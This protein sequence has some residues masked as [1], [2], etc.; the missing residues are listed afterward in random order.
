MSPRHS[1]ESL[2]RRAHR[3]IR[4]EQQMQWVSLVA[5]AVIIGAVAITY[6]ILIRDNRRDLEG[7]SSPAIHVDGNQ[8]VAY[9]SH[10]LSSFVLPEGK[11]LVIDNGTLFFNGVEYSDPADLVGPQGPP[12][13]GTECEAPLATLFWGEEDDDDDHPLETLDF[14]NLADN[15]WFPI[16][17]SRFST[18]VLTHMNETGNG[19]IIVTKNDYYRWGLS[20]DFTSSGMVMHS[21]VVYFA[22]RINGADKPTKYHRRQTICRSVTSTP[23]AEAISQPVANAF[24]HAD[25]VPRS[26]AT[27]RLRDH[28]PQYPPCRGFSRR[29]PLVCHFST[30][31]R[32]NDARQ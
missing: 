25:T 30:L 23:S 16:E 9:L 29:F 2:R 28:P 15:I 32:R 12:G 11:D 20:V 14:E 26:R 21:G 18:R 13:L 24:C 5:L 27:I 8:R 1:A 10:S 3:A 19:T 4:F 17:D 7:V 22:L 31:S 6:G